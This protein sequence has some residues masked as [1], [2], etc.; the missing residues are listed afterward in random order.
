M[1]SCAL[2]SPTSFF[3][4]HSLF[5]REGCITHCYMNPFSFLVTFWLLR[6]KWSKEVMVA[7][8][9]LMH[10]CIFRKKK[11]NLKEF[12]IGVMKYLIII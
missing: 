3:L 6:T 7:E 1:H 2:W 10:G 8:I 4:G 12:T 9:D 11:K 5:L